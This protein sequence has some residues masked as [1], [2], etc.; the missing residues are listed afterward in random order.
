[1][2]PSVI[3]LLIITSILACNNRKVPDVSNIKLD[4]HLERFEH[5][6]FNIDTTN[7]NA[8][9]Q[10]LGKKYPAFVQDFVF[11]IL[12]LP[13]QPDSATAVEA[14]IKSF[15]SSYKS[16]KDSCDKI[17]SDFTDIKQDI[18]R[19]L[20]FVKHYFPSYKVPTKVITFIGPL[21]SYG[22]ILTNDAVA[23]GLQ[24]Y[25]GN[26]FSWYQSEAG[27]QLY[28]A[29]VSARF[30]KEYI[31]VNCM[32][33]IIDDMY[34][35]NDLGRPLVEQMVEAGKRLYL[36]DQLL[37]QTADTL[38]TGYTKKQLE[39]AESNEELIWSFFLQNDLLYA[40]DPAITKDYM[41]D[42]P[43]T[44]AIGEASPGFIGQYVGWKI[45]K[46]WMEKNEKI[47]LEELMNANA[48]TI[49]EQAKYKPR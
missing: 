13:A 24:L 12:A 46:K 35:N 49:F 32:K 22:N 25:M 42:A 3:W 26:S 19:G 8:S 47:T 29:Y 14:G 33:N 27:Q 37:P 7:I 2:K 18:D 4:V 6:F 30:K 45:V 44:A 39:G 5:D 28:P 10:Q 23:V 36:L 20:K 31:P 48:K 9:L 38:K 11:N 41:N 16:L 17:F 21:N 40:T 1:M 34:Q 43:K 15:I